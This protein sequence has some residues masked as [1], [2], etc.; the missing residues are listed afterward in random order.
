MFLMADL[1]KVD[2][3]EY[4]KD[5]VRRAY[6]VPVRGTNPRWQVETIM[7]DLKNDFL[8]KPGNLL[9]ITL[10]DTVATRIPRNARDYSLRVLQ[11]FK[12]SKGIPIAEDYHVMMHCHLFIGPRRESVTIEDALELIAQ[13]HPKSNLSNSS[14]SSK[15]SDCKEEKNV[16]D[17]DEYFDEEKVMKI[18]NGLIDEQQQQQQQSPASSST[19]SSASM[20]E[21]EK[22]L[23]AEELLKTFVPTRELWMSAGGLLTW[24]S[25]NSKELDAITVQ[26]KKYYTL[27]RS[28]PRKL[29]TS[30]TIS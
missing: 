7:V 9:E 23:K 3:V 5:H 26:G 16:I 24:I 12:S 11:E 18:A 4:L 1:Y 28:V 29:R 20:S 30:N 8:V 10:T 27:I 17:D 2:R 19:S 15:S 22:K 21:E 25:H 14:N 6:C 13:S